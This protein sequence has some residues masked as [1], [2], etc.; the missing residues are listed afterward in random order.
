M[1]DVPTNLLVT[2]PLLSRALADGHARLSG[3]AADQRITYVAA[4]QTMRFAEPEEHV[5][6]SYWAEL[7]YQYE[8]DPDTIGIEVVV[9]DRTPL[10]RADIVVFHDAARTRPYAVVECKRD[11][12]TD[13]EFEQAV[14]QA[15]G[16]GTWAKFRADYVVVV[17]GLTRRVLDFTGPYG[18]LERERNIVADLPR[19]YGK[20]QE[21]KYYKGTPIDIAPVT[22]QE[23]ITAIKKCHQS[24]WGG[25][26]LSPPA[27]FGELCKIVFVKISD[28]K[29]KRRAGE[30]YEFQI[31][32]HEPS[33][34]LGERIHALYEIQKTRDPDVFTD[35]IRIDDGTLRSIVSHLEGID[36]SSTDIDVKGLAFEQFMDSFFKGD[37]GQ[38]FTPREIIAFAVAMLHP[39][40]DDYVLDPACGSAGF[41]LHALQAVISEADEYYA[42]GTPQHDR[43]WR[44]FA[45]DRIVGIEINE[46]IARVAKMNMILHED[47]HSN[48]VSAD[49]LGPFE[50]L[51]D[52]NRHLT[53]N[54]FSII[55]T[56][57]PF[58]AQVSLSERP[59]L[60]DFELGR[61][62][63]E[64]G[65]RRVRRAQK[66]EVLYIERIW[67]FLRPGDGRAAIILP[68]GVLTNASLQYVRDFILARFQL[69]AVVSLPSHAFSHYGTS[70]KSSLVFL[71]RPAEGE[72]M[73]LD[74]PVFMAAPE[75]IGYDATGRETASDLDAI[76][77][78]YRAFQADPQAF[79]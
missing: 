56:N 6:A 72:A 2:S 62:L 36:L 3:D 74:E 18:I 12:I 55:L 44:D 53:P 24:L 33:H 23:L 43:H 29:Q 58:G 66:T 52:L 79:L 57:P 59:Y 14:E 8:Y 64:A 21:F 51:A 16:N 69:L 32:T 9:P 40:S 4:N 28:E 34:R 11:G 75:Q 76:V 47:G 1:I 42:P 61:Q 19:R 73:D 26:R 63:D 39:T 7:I 15:V 41:L 10:D 22:K 48:V 35:R 49:A 60:A 77:E 65:R 46:E 20:P 37:F 54:R 45:R 31:K 13:A 27:A 78:S 30:P 5:R 25:G 70:V 68:D 50:H 17:A 67:Q 38:Y 71:R